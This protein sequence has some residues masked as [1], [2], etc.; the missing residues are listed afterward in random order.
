MTNICEFDRILKTECN[1]SPE[2]T[3]LRIWMTLREMRQTLI[4]GEQGF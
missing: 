1:Y 3:E 4:S 2:P